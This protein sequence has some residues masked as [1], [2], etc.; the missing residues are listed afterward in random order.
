MS[1]QAYAGL[2][3]SRGPLNVALH[4]RF[5]AELASFVK[6][7][8]LVEGVTESTVLRFALEQWATTQGFNQDNCS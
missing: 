2:E 5:P 8:A 4:V 6:T 3:R 1:I 7:T